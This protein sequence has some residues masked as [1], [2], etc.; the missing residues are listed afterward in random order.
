ME[1]TDE[2]LLGFALGKLAPNA[3]AIS[4]R[5]AFSC[6]PGHLLDRHRTPQSEPLTERRGIVRASRAGMPRDN[7]GFLRRFRPSRWR[8]THRT[9]R[10]ARDRPW[11]FP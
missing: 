10:V 3:S 7:Q 4:F 8:R 9:A 6:V 11:G 2:C 5:P 1:C